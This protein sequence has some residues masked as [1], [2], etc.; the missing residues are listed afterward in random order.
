MEHP[1]GYKQKRESVTVKSPGNIASPGVKGIWTRD[2]YEF[3]IP[4]KK[5]AAGTKI[6]F[7]APFY[8]RQQ[9]VFWNLKYRDGEQ[10]KT[11]NL[12]EEVCYDGVTSMECTFSLIRGAKTITEVMTFENEVKSG[13]LKIRV[14]CAD[15]AV[16]ASTITAV[17]TREYPFTDKSGYAAPCYFFD[18]SKPDGSD[19]RNSTPEVAAISFSIVD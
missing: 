3:T 15:G 7:K 19:D 1:S 10:W 5:F 11:C 18:K 4:V 16:Q 6:E 2:Y 12:H 8:G 17:E 9:P 14:E 13:F